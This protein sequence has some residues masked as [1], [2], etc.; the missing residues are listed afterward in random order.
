[1]HT[2][3]LKPAAAILS[4]GSL[5][6][7]CRT[8]ETWGPGLDGTQRARRTC[9]PMSTFP[10]AFLIQASRHAT[11][12]ARTSN[13]LLVALQSFLPRRDWQS[14]AGADPR[15][16]RTAAELD[17]HTI[18]ATGMPSGRTASSAEARRARRERP[19]SSGQWRAAQFQGDAKS[20]ATWPK[21]ASRRKRQCGTMTGLRPQGLKETP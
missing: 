18:W 7:F 3:P 11:A 21:V 6:R 12:L 13:L 14:P 5:R 19:Q 20:A 2:S 10:P 8:P 4:S 1:M 16:H 17:R 15:G 9:S